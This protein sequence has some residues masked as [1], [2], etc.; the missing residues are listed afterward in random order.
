MA[1]NVVIT[2]GGAGLGRVMRE[3]FLAQGDHVHVCDIELD[4]T[5]EQTVGAGRLRGT[6]CNMGD[7][8]A[9]SK[10]FDEVA[11][12]M[13]HVDVLINNV[14]IAGPRATLE[15][16]SEHDWLEIIQVNLF[17]A[18]RCMKRVLPGMK[19]RR[20][21]AIV[22]VSTSSVDTL[23]V[24]RSPYNTSKGAIETLTLSVAREVGPFGVR[25]NVLRPG[26]MDNARMQRVLQRVANDS[27]K[28]VAEVL[29]NELQFIS[30][31]TMVS[32]DSVAAM[33]L[34][35]CSPAAAQVTGQVIAVDGGAE[36][37]S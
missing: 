35:L 16:V 33:A 8:N 4:V 15:D 18:I 5:S 29:Q 23:P 32:M 6:V 10:L 31:R 12:W 1:R 7:A 34:Y 30:M 24:N 27:G 37:E 13:P 17:G 20:S 9:V 19:Q 11:A 26:M 22:N 36:W 25:C 2:G 28:S 3:Q 14:G 21:G